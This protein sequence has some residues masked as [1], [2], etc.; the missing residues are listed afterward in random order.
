MKNAWNWVNKLKSKGI[1]DIP[2]WGERD[3]AKRTEENDKILKS[4]AC[5]VGERKMSWKNLKSSFEKSDF[6]LLKKQIH[7]VR[8]I[9]NYI[10]SIESDR[11]F[12]TFWGTFSI[13][14]KTHSIDRNGQKYIEFWE[15]H[16][17]ENLQT[18]FLKQ[19]L[20]AFEQWTQN[21]WVWDGMHFQKPKI[22]IPT[23]LKHK[24]QFS[25]KLIFLKQQN[26]LHTNLKIIFKLG[27]SDQEHTH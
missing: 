3:F 19:L 21:A 20:K 1:R 9:E 25:S 5:L 22:F 10:R 14:R 17:F 24:F 7:D 16:S 18:Q 4:L 11:R 15:K 12:S 2:A 6:L 13:D 26:M 27:W 23:S 8:S